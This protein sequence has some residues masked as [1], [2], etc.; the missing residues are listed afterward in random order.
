MDRIIDQNHINKFKEVLKASNRIVI[1]PH[2]NPDGDAIGS[3]LGLKRFFTNYGKDA[4][5]L[6]PN[7]YPEFL[8]WIDGSSDVV[9]FNQDNEKG[10][11]LLERADTLFVLDFNNFDRSEGLAEPLKNFEG[12]RVMIDH[13]PNPNAK[14]D[15]MISYPQVGSTCEL[16]YRVIER[17]GLL[18]YLDKSAAEGIFTGMMTDTGNFS[19]N[20]S[21]PE[22]YRII[23]GLLEKGIDKD[24]IHSSVFHTFSAD[25]WRLVGHSLTNK[26]VI[27]PE[28]NTGFISLTEAEL[29]SFNFQAGDTEGLVNFPLNIKG[30]VFAVLFMEKD[31][32]V[33]ISLRSKGQFSVND[34]SRAHFNGGGHRNAAGGKSHLKMEDAIEKLKGLLPEYK[35]QLKNSL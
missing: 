20:A 4:Q 25:R 2:V 23:A 5:V 15:V 1:V 21:D 8:R 26:M 32:I 13:H 27:I 28:Y 34:F 3:S 12:K 17:S 6:I 9:D 33:K 22:T 18:Q 10:K 24:G 19:Y 14:V 35:S 16:V 29:E 7:N 31:D 30:I 11:N